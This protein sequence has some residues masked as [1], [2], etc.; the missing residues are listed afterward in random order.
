[1]AKEESWGAQVLREGVTTSMQSYEYKAKER[2]KA[3]RLER[4]TT[5]T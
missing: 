2:E 3:I 1:M 4:N 5:R